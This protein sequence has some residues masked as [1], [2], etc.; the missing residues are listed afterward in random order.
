MNDDN[1]RLAHA[2]WD[3][4]YRFRNAQGAVIDQNL[5][6]TW[7]RVASTIAT[8]EPGNR[9]EWR[10]RFY[11]LLQSGAFLPAGRILAGAGVDR[12]VTL[13]NCFVMQQPIDNDAIIQR[14]MQEC[15]LTLQH[16]GGIG[17]DFSALAPQDFRVTPQSKPA[18]GPV[19][20][21]HTWDQ[22]CTQLSS[23]IHRRCAM[24]ATLRCDH[25]D[26]EKFI[27]AKREPGSLTHFNLSV[28]VTE[29]FLQ[30]VSQDGDWLLTFPAVSRRVRAREL[31]ESIMQANYQYA[32]PGV[33]FID[34]INRLNNLHYRETI[35]CT[36]P[37]GEI[38]LPEYGACNLGSLNLVHFVEHPFTP[39]ARINF[40]KLRETTWLATRLLD[41]VI[42]V[43]A[44]PLA[45]QK[46]E[47]LATRRIG[48]GI[49][50][51][52]DLLAMLQL[53]YY[54]QAARDVAARIMQTI[55]QT[56]YLGS[57]ALAKEKGCFPTFESGH[58][59]AG[60]HAQALPEA[61]RES[62]SQNGLRN[63]HL[64]AIA[65]T[66]SISLLA[67]NIS[68]GIEPLYGLNFKHRTSVS[69]HEEFFHVSAYA[70]Q[71]W[72][73]KG[74]PC[75]FIPDFFTCAHEISPEQQLLMVG[76][77]QP[78]VDSAISK[79]INLPETIPFTDFAGIYLR[80]NEL[81]LK[82]CTTFRSRAT[83]VLCHSP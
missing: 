13:L 32:E 12:A 45:Q 20:H 6:D 1:A 64:T 14:Q 21:L 38:P 73:A 82:G 28:L 36:N 43:T 51:L 76:A 65:P 55:Q 24:I 41:N 53:P 8:A 30:A 11:Y 68:S 34:R 75:D 48:L 18:L 26:I 25:P 7:L 49:F 72:L 17:C 9:T 78:F 39:D 16:G 50:G 40:E 69:G 70:W 62:I 15:A 46:N 42:D 71:Q 47:V 37:C 61:I 10:N 35:S 66:G 52:A 5:N 80:A 23:G 81:G 57:C 60:I 74:N 58:F 63:S 27:T 2:I 22:L 56:A 29:A 59:L 33:L 77:I 3:A 19:H 67:G 54:S 44:F 31:W 83:A 79:T 4:K